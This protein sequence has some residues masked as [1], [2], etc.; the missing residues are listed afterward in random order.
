ME[1]ATLWDHFSP[2]AVGNK[3]LTGFF[4]SL[5]ESGHRLAFKTILW[6]NLTL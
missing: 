6:Q 3:K 5:L 1:G 4:S 2:A